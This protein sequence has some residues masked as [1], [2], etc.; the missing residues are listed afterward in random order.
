MCTNVENP[1]RMIQVE[2]V[3]NWHPRWREVLDAIEFL[4]QRDGLQ[5]D[6]DG[7]LPARQNLLVAFADEMIAGHLSFCVQPSRNAADQRDVEAQLQ[8]LGVQPEFAQEQIRTLLRAAAEQ[9]AESL[10]CHR[11]VGF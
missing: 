7:W 6:R 11:L 4:G 2:L 1:H 8:T 10:R 9:R 3:D 5:V